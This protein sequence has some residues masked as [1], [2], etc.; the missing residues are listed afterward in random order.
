MRSTTLALIALCVAGCATLTQDS[1]DQRYGR[2]DTTRS[3]ARLSLL[4]ATSSIV[5]VIFRVF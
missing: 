2:A 1:L 5:R 3:W 4:V